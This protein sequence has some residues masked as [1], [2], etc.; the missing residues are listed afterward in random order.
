MDLMDNTIRDLKN[1][2]TT[3]TDKL[4]QCETELVTTKG[5]LLEEK[6]FMNLHR[7]TIERLEANIK[8]CDPE[9]I[10]FDIADIDDD[11]KDFVYICAKNDYSVSISDNH[12][13]VRK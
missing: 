5:E 12:I 11:R 6:T 9:N 13:W 2:V 1:K 10:G 4:T 3:L 7:Q 8:E